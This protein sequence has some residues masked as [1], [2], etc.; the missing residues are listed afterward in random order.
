MPRTL[1]I[2][3]IQNDYFPGGAYPLPGAERAAG[4]AARLLG[5]WRANGDVVV[6]LQHVWDAPDAEFMRPGTPGVEIH[7]KVAPGP[8]EPVLTKEAPNGFLGT[9]LEQELRAADTEEL[10]VAGMMTSMCVDA[11]VRAASDLGFQVTVATDA[12]AAPDLE[13]DGTQVPA[14]SVHAAFIAALGDSYARLE[15]VAGLI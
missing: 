3:D 9:S 12:C 14:A 11:T 8:D 1:L 13:F 15:S 2:I 6:H 10:V 4:E 7:A 5:A